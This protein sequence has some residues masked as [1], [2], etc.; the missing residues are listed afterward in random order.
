[1]DA[2]YFRATDK[3]SPHCYPILNLIGGGIAE[4]RGREGSI[5]V[6]RKDAAVRIQAGSHQRES[7][8]VATQVNHGA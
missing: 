2:V 1:L 5:R 6:D 3:F 8:A 7:P 4:R